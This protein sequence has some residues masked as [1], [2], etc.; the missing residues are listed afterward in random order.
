MTDYDSTLKNVIVA[1]PPETIINTLGEYISALGYSQL[2]IAETEKYAHVTFFFNGGNEA[3]Y[4]NEDRIL[5]PSPKVATY[6]LKPEMSANEVADKVVDDLN[7]S[8]HDVVIM[9]FAN[10][11]MVG[12]TGNFAKTVEALEALDKCVERIIK[13]LTINDGEAIIIADHGNSEYMEDKN[14]KVVTSHSTFNVPMIVVS[15]RVRDLK[16]GSLSDVSPSLLTLMGEKK[17]NE[18]SGNSLIELK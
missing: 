7:N 1:Y 14:G 12:H 5:I 3:P 6:D 11:D 16:V 13:T 9:N 17:P 2:R 18:M 4:K 15:K 10:G 8:R